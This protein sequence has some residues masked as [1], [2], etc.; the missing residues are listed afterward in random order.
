[1]TTTTINGK[2]FFFLFFFMLIFCFSYDNYLN[3]DNGHEDNHQQ[4]HHQRCLTPESLGASGSNSAGDS[5]QRL[6]TCRG[7]VFFLFYLLH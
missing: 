4:Q 2:G 5:Q 6:E 3:H 1:M 7:Y